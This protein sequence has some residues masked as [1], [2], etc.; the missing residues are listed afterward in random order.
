MSWFMSKLTAH[1]KHWK[2]KVHSIPI[3]FIQLYYQKRLKFLVYSLHSWLH[4][5]TSRLSFPYIFLCILREGFIYHPGLWGW[6]WLPIP[7]LKSLNWGL[8][9]ES[10][11]T[12]YKELCPSTWTCLVLVFFYILFVLHKE[13]SVVYNSQSKHKNKTLKK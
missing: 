9:L 11:T 4:K 1:I 3:I 10:E 6:R 12:F 13:S 2:G 8:K 5:N 7:A